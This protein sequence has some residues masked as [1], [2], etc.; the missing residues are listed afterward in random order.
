MMQ[1]I[2]NQKQNNGWL[3]ALLLL[4]LSLWCISPPLFINGAARIAALMCAIVFLFLALLSSRSKDRW[5][6]ILC[7]LIYSL[8]KI[9]ANLNADFNDFILANIQIFIII[10]FSL[11]GVCF[12]WAGNGRR[13]YEKIFWAV[14]LI[15]PVWMLL[16]LREYMVTP[17]ISR[18]LSGNGMADAYAYSNMGIGGYGMIYS[19]VFL[20]PLIVYA[21]KNGRI[22][23]RPQKVLLLLNLL[24]S[25]L[26]VLRSGYALALIAA[27]IGIL[28]ILIIRKRSIATVAMLV[29][30]FLIVILAYMT[31]QDRINAFLIKISQSTLYEGKVN[32]IIYLLVTGDSVGTVQSRVLRYSWSMQIFLQSP[33]FGCANEA[34]IGGHSTIL[35]T[36]AAYGLAGGLPLLFIIIH[37]PV[38]Y[39]RDEPRFFGISITMLML[40]ILVGVT[41]NYAAAMAPVVYLMYPILIE[42]IR[43]KKPTEKNVTL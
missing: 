33:F 5:K 24:L 3:K 35:D 28:S 9:V 37:L 12:L 41:D 31:F 19:V 17:N 21:L 14:L 20:I 32:D 29:F 38:Q 34:V 16:T 8:Y 7:V 22:F 11:I 23:T 18:M 2:A 6:I 15:Y 30:G 39:M 42:M 10:L 13:V 40:L 36:F 1:E 25:I 27:T 26:L 43:R 4:F